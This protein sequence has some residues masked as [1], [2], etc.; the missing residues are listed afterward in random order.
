MPLGGSLTGATEPQG[1]GGMLAALAL[2][3]S[4][5]D[6]RPEKFGDMHYEGAFPLPGLTGEYDVML[7]RY[8][9]VV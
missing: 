5:T 4:P 3:A 1:S 2:L 7:G 6:A 9:G 8:G